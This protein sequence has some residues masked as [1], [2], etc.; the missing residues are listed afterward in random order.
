MFPASNST[1]N[2]PPHPS[3]SFHSSSPFLGL[4]GNQILLHHYQNQLS[5]HHFAKNMTLSANNIIN[6]PKYHQNHSDNSLRS[7]PI[8]KKPKKRERF[9]KILTSQGP[10]DR[11][12]RL[13]IAIARK[14]FDLQEILGFDKPSKTLDWLFTNSK[15]AIEE[16]ANWST[17]QDHHPKI[18]GATKSS[19]NETAKDCASQCE[20]LAITTNEGSERKP[21]RAKEKK[22]VK[23][24]ATDL[25]LVARESRAKARARA[26]ERTIK[27]MWSRIETS[28]RSTSQ[29]IRSSFHPNFSAPIESSTTYYGSSSFNTENLDKGTTSELQGRWKQWDSSHSN[30]I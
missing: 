15:L 10:R 5:S 2:P 3:L 27:K 4:N 18:A 22:E 24:E 26:R 21:K 12:V 30:Q 25:V 17:H 11:R 19:C 29:L 1:G 14:F 16:L 7:F 20:D 13:S 8:N 6:S 9:S 23:D 28:Q